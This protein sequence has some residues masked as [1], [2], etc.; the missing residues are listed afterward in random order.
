[1]ALLLLLAD[2]KFRECYQHR[3][4]QIFALKSMVIEPRLTF[5]SFSS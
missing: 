5:F 2:L 1:M 3:F 4:R